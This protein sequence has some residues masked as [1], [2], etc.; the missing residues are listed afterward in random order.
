[1]NINGDESV[2]GGEADSA[3][4]AYLADFM[5][6]KTE[7]GYP[8]MAALA[9]HPTEANPEAPTNYYSSETWTTTSADD[10]QLS[11]VHYS[12]ENPTGKWVILVHGYGKI[13]EA[14]NNF[15][16]P[17][18]A[19]GVDVLVVDQRAAGNSAGEW[20]TMGV[21]EAADIAIWTQE[22]EKTNANAQI[23]LH[24]VSM[25]AATVMMAAALNQTT[26]VTGMI[27]DCG[28]G[29]I[30]DVLI[31]LLTAYGSNFGIRHLVLH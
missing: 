20:L 10:L 26:N 12:P 27:E 4:A 6:H 24:G 18:L 22:I 21:A 25:G 9:F 15:A 30:A 19:Q 5:L 14:M 7:A 13:G 29:N 17:Y 11:A 1:M 2:I 16:E 3:A 23:T 31:G 28:Y 8:Q